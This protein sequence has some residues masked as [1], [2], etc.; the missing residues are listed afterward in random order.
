M[1]VPGYKLSGQVDPVFTAVDE[2]DRELLS[3]PSES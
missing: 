3:V 1:T 2:P